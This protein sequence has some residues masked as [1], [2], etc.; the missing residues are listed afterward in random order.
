MN[1]SIPGRRPDH[2]PAILIAALAAT[3]LAAACSSDSNHGTPGNPAE[4]GGG[5][6]SATTG[7]GG[8][9]TGTSGQGAT[10]AIGGQAGGSGGTSAG[11]GSGGHAGSGGSKGAGSGGVPG[12]ADAGSR[13][14]NDAGV[15][16][17]DAGT[18]M[19]PGADDL[20]AAPDG[21]DAAPGTLDAPTT[22]TAA[23]TRISAGHAVYLRGGSYTYAVQITIARDNSGTSAQPKALAPYRDEVPVLDFSS[24]PYGTGSNPRGLQIDGSHW[25]VVGLTVT[26]SA[27]NGIYVSGNDNVI[28]RCITH[29]NHDTGLQLGRYASSATSQADWPSNNLILNCESYDNYDA[30]PGSGENADGFGAKLTVGPGNVFRGCVSHNNID[31]GWDLY[32]KSDTGPIGSVTIDQCISH[33]NGTLTDGTQNANGDRNGFKL[34]G[35]KIAVAHTVTRSVAFA[36]GKDGF[37]WNSNPGATRLS[38]TLSFDNGS[39]NYRFGD[40]STQTQA[41]FTNDVSFRTASG[42]DNDKTVGSDVSNSN[43]WLP[44][45][46]G[47]GLMVS[48]ADFAH[49]LASAKITRNADGSIDFSPFA[50]AAGSDLI[51]AGVVP[52]G[53]LPFDA[54]YYQGNPDLGAVETE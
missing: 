21:K 32:T 51:N 47:K 34:G 25:H 28:E 37:T 17:A 49:P 19:T 11:A 4:T 31:D 20:I 26:G 48:A 30:P 7:S 22:L 15:T 38:N 6:S 10:G 52:A 5:G 40:N 1:C 2:R 44:N 3:F 54:S 50:L 13:A 18:S 23:I 42:G 24:Q 27:D 35:D 33:H 45:T 9:A 46:N 16:P 39:A 12:A 36:N 41:V 8:S 29:G 14:Q 53:T 43:C